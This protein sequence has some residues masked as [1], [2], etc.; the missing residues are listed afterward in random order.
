WRHTS[1]FCPFSFSLQQSLVITVQLPHLADIKM[2]SSLSYLISLRKSAKRMVTPSIQTHYT[3]L[4]KRKGDPNRFRNVAE[5]F[6]RACLG[7]CSPQMS[8]DTFTVLDL[9]VSLD[10]D[11]SDYCAIIYVVLD[12][13]VSSNSQEN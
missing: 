9:R 5:C 2:T 3:R 8:S 13:V 7:V 4:V 6:L 1:L 12:D 10:H 11:S